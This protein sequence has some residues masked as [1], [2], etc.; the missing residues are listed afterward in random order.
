MSDSSGHTRPRN[1]A[2]LLILP[3]F[4]AW[5]MLGLEG[6]AEKSTVPC[7]WQ[8]RADRTEFLTS[9]SVEIT[10]LGRLALPLPGRWLCFSAHADS[11]LVEHFQRHLSDLGAQNPFSEMT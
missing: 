9:A 4:F 11:C 5:I 7:V 10:F 6:L 8:G 3:W 2:W 1:T